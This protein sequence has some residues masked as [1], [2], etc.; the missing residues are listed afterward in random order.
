MVMIIRYSDG[1]YVEGVIRRLDGG[2]LRAAVAGLDDAVEYTLMQDKWISETGL[3]VTLDFP[4]EKARD[5]FPIVPLMTC[6]PEGC[7]IGGDCVLRRTSGSC[8]GTVN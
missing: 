2:T 8:A 7:A 5:R 4:I 3:V 1:S 6:Q